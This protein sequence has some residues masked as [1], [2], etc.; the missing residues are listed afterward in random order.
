[1][2]DIVVFEYCFLLQCVLPSHTCEVVRLRGPL[3]VYL[4]CYYPYLAT[5]GTTSIF[6]QITPDID[7]KGNISP[8]V[9][10]LKIDREEDCG[11]HLDGPHG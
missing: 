2:F 6:S 3:S 8:V 4:C 1:M 10:K 7:Q 5:P 11:P 9:T